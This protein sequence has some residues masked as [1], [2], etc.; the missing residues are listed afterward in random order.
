MYRSLAGQKVV[1]P[2]GLRPGIM[3]LYLTF[4]I[5]CFIGFWA[6]PLISNDTL[7]NPARSSDSPVIA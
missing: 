4:G 5:I 3:F 1:W 2:F 7:N 6:T